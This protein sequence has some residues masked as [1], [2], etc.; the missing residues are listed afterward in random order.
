MN[1]I[2]TQP[3][4]FAFSLNFIPPL[5]QVI[6]DSAILYHLGTIFGHQL[7]WKS[8]WFSRGIMWPYPIPQLLL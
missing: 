6:P 8:W 3:M 2:L 1:R 4:V 5:S 7:K